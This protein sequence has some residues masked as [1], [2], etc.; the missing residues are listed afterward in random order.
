MFLYFFLLLASYK[1]NLYFGRQ[2]LQM[3]GLSGQ[4]MPSQ[5]PHN[6]LW[7]M[8]QDGRCIIF[9]CGKI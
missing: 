5:K 9:E 3:F 6:A 1:K 8:I 4:E 7:A 2:I